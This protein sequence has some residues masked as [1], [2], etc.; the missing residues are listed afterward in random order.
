MK[1]VSPC[2]QEACAIQAC[3][4]LNSFKDEKCTAQIKDLYECCRRFYA[5]NGVDS[6]NKCCPKPDLLELKLDQMKE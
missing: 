4:R 6:T 5:R 2:K 1:D 3:L